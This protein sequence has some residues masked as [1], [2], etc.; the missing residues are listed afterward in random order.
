MNITRGWLLDQTKDHLAQYSLPTVLNQMP[1]ARPE[2]NNYLCSPTTGTD[3]FIHCWLAARMPTHRMFPSV[4]NEFRNIEEKWKHYFSK[5]SLNSWPIEHK[6]WFEA[7]RKKAVT[8]TIIVDPHPAPVMWGRLFS[9]GNVGERKG[10][11]CSATFST[12]LFFHGFFF[13]FV[14]MHQS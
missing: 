9:E 14:E 6:F 8:T 13:P 1:H 10:K 7:P 12:T 5:P 2:C 4:D 11:T 3:G